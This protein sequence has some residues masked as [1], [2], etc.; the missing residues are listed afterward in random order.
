VEKH[1]QPTEDSKFDSKS[2][3]R[4]SVSNINKA[5]ST[6]E[7]ASHVENSHL[8]ME[9]L[10]VQEI[11]IEATL[12]IS[13]ISSLP[14]YYDFKE[15]FWPLYSELIMYHTYF[16][17]L[18]PRNPPTE[19]PK[20]FILQIKKAC[21]SNKLIFKESYVYKSISED[22][23]KGM[24][25]PVKLYISSLKPGL[26]YIEKTLG[27]VCTKY[28]MVHVGLQVGPWLLAGLL[29]WT[30]SGLIL[31]RMISSSRGCAVACIDLNNQRHMPNKEFF[32]KVCKIVTT[33]NKYMN[34]SNTASS[35]KELKKCLR[36][37]STATSNCH[38]F[39]E[40]AKDELELNF[41]CHFLFLCFCFRQK[42]TEEN[43]S[44][45]NNTRKDPQHSRDSNFILKG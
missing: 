6:F 2:D 8:A 16:D 19:I 18:V 30:S 29:D 1:V 21:E 7:V 27:K 13:K 10:R 20:S 31:P 39:L 22:I 33:Y 11:G 28:G 43:S 42:D 5:K 35:L 3:S 40:Y 4:V 41:W 45:K 36:K 23:G 37:M 17:F 24:P 26:S 38:L 44:E 9:Y 34:Y 25:V 15:D 12:L 32:M 14:D